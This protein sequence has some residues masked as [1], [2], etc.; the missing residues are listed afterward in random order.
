MHKNGVLITFEG[1]EG[2]GKSTHIRLLA[3]YLKSR[4][5]SVFVTRQP[6]G[7]AIAAPLR[8]ILLQTGEG[9][10][11]L[12]ELFLYEA[13]RAQH[14][15]ELIRPALTRGAVVLCD[16]FTDSTV[17]YQGFGRGL[18]LQLVRSLNAAAAQGVKP[19]LTILLDVPV[20]RGLRLASKAKRGS[21]RLER[22]GLAFH[23]RVRRGFLALA[24][25]EPRRFRLVR[26]QI[27]P[28]AT[29]ARIRSAVD[30]YLKL[31]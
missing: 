29:Q 6:G 3:Q 24:A 20:E 25:R 21:D 28:A 18:D 10:T 15:D 4:G 12:A 13:D 2:S 30:R 16:R 22:A 27:D 8:T 7:S 1:P 26:Q 31:A 11:A 17:A 9:L 5:R 19:Q 23:R 14:V